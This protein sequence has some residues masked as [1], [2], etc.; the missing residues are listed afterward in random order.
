MKKK[1][2]FFDIDGTLLSET[3]HKIQ[4][5]AI[6]AIHTLQKNGHLAFINTGRTF[7]FLD[8]D[9][10]EIGFDGFLCGC[11]TYIQYKNEELCHHRLPEELCKRII[12]LLRECELN[13]ILEG[14]EKSYGEVY[15][16]VHSQIFRDF[17][18]QYQFPYDTWDAK[19]ISFD[20]FFM[21]AGTNNKFQQ[22]K[23]ELENV[24]EFINR[25]HGFFEAVPKGYSKAS[26]MKE[27]AEFL[28]V[29]MSD[30]IAIGDSNND[31]A[32]LQAAG[33][34]IAMGNAT[35]ELLDIADYVTADV[36][37]NGIYKALQYYKL[38]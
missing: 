32:M 29:D 24:F 6:D 15:E 35:K 10:M 16:R 34:G 14:K 30:T 25:E 22:F 27:I 26:A 8:E 36:D 21:Y 7:A 19:N 20:K 4:E 33:T 11:G 37:D 31:L 9:I 12:D 3:T 28:R 13:A 2:V 18:D 38:I 5:S 23:S 1:I 17:I